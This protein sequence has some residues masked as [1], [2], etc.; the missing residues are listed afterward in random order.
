MGDLISG[1][2]RLSSVRSISVAGCVL[3]SFTCCPAAFLE[4]GTSPDLH[5][6][7]SLSSLTCRSIVAEII[8]LTFLYISFI[9]SSHHN[10]TTHTDENSVHKMSSSRSFPRDPSLSLLRMFPPL[11]TCRSQL[12]SPLHLAPQ[13][14]SQP[15][16]VHCRSWRPSQSSP[17]VL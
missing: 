9:L 3:S 8:F 13:Y 5:L 1:R 6:M 4:L 14:P 11:L 2:S 15:K 10:K 17:S 16:V 7:L 12:S